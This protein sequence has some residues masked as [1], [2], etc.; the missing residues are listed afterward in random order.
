MTNTNTKTKTKTEATPAKTANGPS[1]SKGGSDQVVS[2][3]KRHEEERKRLPIYSARDAILAGIKKHPSVI[4]VGETGSGK[5]TQIPQYIL[6][7]GWAQYGAIAVTQPRR[8]AATS[9][10]RRVAEEAGTKLGQR[11]GYTVRFDDTSS[12]HT[13]LKYLTDGMLMREILSDPLLH[14]YNYVLLDEAHERTLRTDILF[15]M[16][17]DIQS[18]RHQLKPN[19]SATTTPRIVDELKIIVMSATLDA[20]RFAK[21][22]NNAEILYVE[23]RQFPVRVFNTLEPQPDYLDSALVT[24]LQIHTE[25]GPGDVLVFLTGQEEIENLEK[26][27]L[28]QR[29]RLPA[30]A[31]DLLVCPLF[32]ALP[33]AQQ[34]L[35]FTPAPPRTRKIIL[36]TNIAETSITLPGIRYVIDT[37]VHKSR[38]YSSKI[39]IE[40]LLVA[41]ISKSS[42]RQRTGRAGREALGYCYRLYTEDGFAQLEEDSEPEILRCNLA[43]AI[44]QLK[45]AGVND[46][47]DFDYMDRPPKLALLRALEQLYALNALDDTGRLSKLGKWMAEFPL[48]PCFAKVLF[49]SQAHQCTHEVIDIIALLSV[50]TLFMMPF[51]KREEAAE[52]RQKF[53]SL[54]GDHITFLNLQKAYQSVKGDSQWCSDHFVNHRGMHHVQE[55][56][57]QL[58]QVCERVKVNPNVSCGHDFDRVLQCFTTGFF[59]QTALLQPDGTYRS[60]IGSQ[61]VRIHP[62]STLFGKRHEAILYNELVFTTRL[63]VRG[64][65]AIQANWIPEASPRYFRQGQLTAKAALPSV[66]GP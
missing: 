32:A 61:Y 59:H 16:L 19:G 57:K 22:F 39:G 48:D 63:Y 27:L 25:Q 28:E 30:E 56:R 4:I 36:A 35:V 44:L 3:P 8:V 42:A 9:L 40:S 66:K 10:A 52:A 65:S 64:V 21:Y 60:V 49:E 2:I 31:Q 24:A 46:V 7:A 37:G 13:K 14:R 41:P 34:A 18:K 20:E 6:E 17:K 54:D 45:A 5:T 12:P 1:R 15:G 38:G 47:L 33:P 43:A 26:L 11:V 55:V 50:D 62:S 53:T 29:Q 58:R 51:H 23:G